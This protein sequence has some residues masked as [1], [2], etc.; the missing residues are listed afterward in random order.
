MNNRMPM[1]FIGHGSPMNAIEDNDYTAGWQRIAS[2]LKKPKAI[3]SVSAHW[4]TEG[5]RVNDSETPKTI[6]D[7][8]GFPDALYKVK[9]DAS[10]SPSFAQKTKSLL[11]KEV[12]VDNTWGIDHG[13]WSVLC[14]MFPEADIPVY[15]LSLDRNAS[16]KKHFENGR[17][18]SALREEGVLILGSGNVVHNLSKVNFRM[19][20]GF[21]WADEFDQYVIQHIKNGT[22][23]G[24]LDYNCA[25][26]SAQMAFYTTEHY[27]PLLYVLG[28]AKPDDKLTVFNDSRIYGALSMT[29]FL[30]E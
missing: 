29:S 2:G 6:Y 1:L 9:Y 7:M 23:D 8:Y 11:T 14:R 19:S 16:A 25:G 5:T 22:Y 10:G 24:V 30:F 13:T 4:V 28:A 18:I 20:G 12:K 26:E 15:Q 21:E 17:A 27:D 3:L